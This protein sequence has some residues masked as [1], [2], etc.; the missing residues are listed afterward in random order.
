MENSGLNWQDSLNQGLVNR[1]HRPLRQPGM[2]KMAMSQRIINRGDRFLNRLPLLN[3]Q[4]QRWGHT[5]SLSSDST[6]VVYAQP[7]S[8]PQTQ[9]IEN[10]NPSFQSTISPNNSPAPLIQ[11]KLDSSQKS[12]TTVNHAPVIPTN[13]TDEKTQSLIL[14][15][16]INQPSISDSEMPVVSPQT[17]TEASPTTAEMP[18]QAKFNNSQTSA[19][20]SPS[21]ADSKIINE[22]LISASEMPVVSPQT[23]TKASPTTAEIPLQAKI[24]NSQISALNPLSITDSRTINETAISS[25][26]PVVSPQPTSEELTQNQEL[27][28]GQ[29]L[30]SISKQ[31]LPIIQA[32]HQNN[33]LSPSTIN[34]VNYL[35]NSEPQ[36]QVQQVNNSTNLK[37][38]SYSTN[39][40]IVSVTSVINP[41]A[42]T[43]SLPLAKTAPFSTSNNQQPNLSNRN[44][45]ISTTD[46]FSSPSQSF[47]SPFSSLQ[48][49]ASPTTTQSNIDVNSIANQVERKLMR[50]L[51][52]ESERRGKNQ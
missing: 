5:H 52:I 2:M 8:L 24:N 41:P 38:Q 35:S 46:S 4:M 48:T 1:L 17:S 21:I 9:G 6:K 42:K 16:Q 3:Q 51:V 37:P 13:F 43:E 44:P 28:L 20:N 23:S 36:T 30:T 33:S 22:T 50:R 39:L 29:E 26:I 27:P 45:K 15:T 47:S 18:L 34:I 31:P 40:P 14:E 10:I 25:P 11:R 12:P 7:V 19:L 32:K 49:S